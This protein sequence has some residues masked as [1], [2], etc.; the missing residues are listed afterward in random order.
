MNMKRLI[1]FLLI[2][3]PFFTLAQEGQPTLQQPGTPLDYSQAAPA[4]PEAMLEK[5]NQ[6][7]MDQE[8]DKA[9]A[10]Y[11]QILGTGKESAQVYFNLA[12]AAYKLNDIPK[13]ILNYERAKLLDPSNEDI[14]FNL[15][16]A[17]QFAVDNIQA[18]PQP[19]FVRW[20]TSV[21]NL[22]SAATWPK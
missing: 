1:F 5:A 3:L 21:V 9:A 17:G 12:N 13:A 15:R 22:A 19:F 18:L 14:D 11:E 6:H 10:L 7:Y 20:R 4:E 16:V 8:F 2:L